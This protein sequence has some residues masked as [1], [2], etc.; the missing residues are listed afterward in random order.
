MKTT[1]YT[2]FS[3]I[4][5]F[6]PLYA[7]TLEVPGT[8]ATIQAAIDAAVDGDTVLV[9]SGTYYE[10][11]NFNHKKITVKS[12]NGTTDTVIDANGAGSVVTFTSAEDLDSVI[13][14]F[15]ITNGVNGSGA[16]VMCGGSSPTIINN[17]ING[18]EGAAG[19]GIA[20][21]SGSPHVEGN[22]I[23]DNTAMVLGGGI[24]CNSSDA[25]VINNTFYGNFSGAKGGAIN[26]SGGNPTV[27]YNVVYE[28]TADMHGGG[29]ATDNNT[30]TIDNNV[31]WGNTATANGGGIYVE[32]ASPLI[33]HNTIV[34]NTADSHGGGIGIDGT[35]DVTVCN[36][37]LWDDFSPFGMEIWANYS[38]A[39]VTVRYCDVDM[40][41]TGDGN[42]NSDPLFADQTNKD[43]HL[44]WLSPCVNRGNNA[45]ATEFDMEEDKR[46]YVSIVDMGADEYTGLHA[47]DADTFT[48]DYRGGVV[49]MDL[50]S[51][52]DFADRK[53]F[54]LAGATGTNP[55]TALP[56][57]LAT[58]PLNWDVF[59]DLVLSLTGFPIFVDFSG[60]L[61]AN[62]QAQA[63]LNLTVPLDPTTV[64]T[65]IYFA[66]LNYYPFDFASNAI[67]VEIVDE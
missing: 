25:V 28:N 7:D 37:I 42:I 56:D 22:T 48:L 62:G 47:L 11:I 67:A 36:C 39:T 59:T 65:V 27:S 35:S 15:T 31:I 8:Y 66:Y 30:M 49:N 44:T 33:V 4:L 5:L 51:G 13:D 10:N 1:L 38:T 23:F 3:C 24:F 29:I 20:A 14:G 40:G 6:V 61:D 41:F 12:V 34:E 32:A 55:G 54:V 53:Y 2:L 63:Q 58:L 52:I 60:R 50:D 9:D 43:L 64:G 46:P 26:V 16:G 21:F 17:I 57:N 18:N 19:V 45:D